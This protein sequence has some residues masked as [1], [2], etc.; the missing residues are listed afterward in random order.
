[1]FSY[2][3]GKLIDCFE[4]KLI[5]ECNNVGYEIFVSNNTFCDF[6][7]G[8]DIKIYT[9]LV[10][11][12]DNVALFGFSGLSE[13]SMFLRLITVTGIGP[14]IALSILSGMSID[15][16]AVSIAQGDSLM[17]TRIKGVGK[18]MA[19]RIVLE[20]KEKVEGDVIDKQFKNSTES[21]VVQALL[22]LGLSRYECQAAVKTA[23]ENGAV[24]TEEI[25]KLALKS[26]GKK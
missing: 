13:K 18:K 9:Y 12:D 17:L 15:D 10:A 7:I 3:N 24:T 1:M 11:R 5:V 23:V 22:A 26:I 20:L 16:L 14:K 25:I 2:I 8:Q 21:D 4:N 19:E 6:K